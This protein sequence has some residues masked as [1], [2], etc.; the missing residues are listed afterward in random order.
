MKGCRVPPP[1]F[2]LSLRRASWNALNVTQSRKMFCVPNI[3]LKA[4]LTSRYQERICQFHF[5]FEGT[6]VKPPSTKWDSMIMMFDSQIYTSER[7]STPAPQLGFQVKTLLYGTEQKTLGKLEAN[8]VSEPMEQ[9][10]ALVSALKCERQDQRTRQN[11]ICIFTDEFSSSV[12]AEEGRFLRNHLQQECTAFK[13]VAVPTLAYCMEMIIT[14]HLLFFPHALMWV[15]MIRCFS[16]H[17]C[18]H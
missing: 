13:N 15:L 1:V 18:Q 16:N 11:W 2:W 14:P 8:M 5:P 4:A 10:A 17:S 6:T 12:W 9:P 7:S 3:K